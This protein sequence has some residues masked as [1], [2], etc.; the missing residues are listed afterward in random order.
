MIQ[1]VKKIYTPL[2]RKLVC[3]TKKHCWEQNEEQT[4]ETRNEEGD[5]GMRRVKQLPDSRV[6]A[7]EHGLANWTIA[8]RTI[9]PSLA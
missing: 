4:Q 3:A 7:T 8:E 9:T 5:G 6:C 2:D 1:R